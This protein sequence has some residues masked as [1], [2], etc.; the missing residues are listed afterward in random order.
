MISSESAFQNIKTVQ[1]ALPSDHL[2]MTVKLDL[3]KLRRQDSD[4]EEGVSGTP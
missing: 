2:K 4:N 1:E 3:S